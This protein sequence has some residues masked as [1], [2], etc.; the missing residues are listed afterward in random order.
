MDIST[1][2]IYLLSV[3]SV[4]FV[5]SSQYTGYEVDIFLYMMLG[6]FVIGLLTLDENDK[7]WYAYIFHHLI[8]IISIVIVLDGNQKDREFVIKYLTYEISTPLLNLS[9]YY[10]DKGIQALWINLGFLILYTISRIIY[11]T[12]LTYEV[13]SYL[14]GSCLILLPLIMQGIIY[15]WYYKILRIAYKTIFKSKKEYYEL[16]PL[17]LSKKPAKQYLEP[18]NFRRDCYKLGSLVINDGFKPDFMVALWRGGAPVGCYVHEL[19]KYKEINT[20]HIAIRTSR[21][22]GID[23]TNEEILVHNFTYL[24]DVVKQ[25]SKILLVDD[26]WD[27]GLSI[28]AVIYKFKQE[29]PKIFETLDFRVATVYF[30]PSRN[31]ILETPHYYVHE[32]DEWLVFPHELEGMTIKEIKYVMGTEIA[33]IIDSC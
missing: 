15:W 30:K 29:F 32:S 5:Y 3:I 4:Q 27:S 16:T 1:F 12:Y 22:S 23:K 28:H 18:N 33:N 25:F 6:Y 10:R 26:V 17:I 24:K 9:L 21:Y 7:D 31:K 13:I 20:D 2:V 8:G 11:G 14:D 19:L